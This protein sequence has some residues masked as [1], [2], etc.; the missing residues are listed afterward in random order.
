MNYVHVLNRCS[1]CCRFYGPTYRTHTQLVCLVGR[2]STRTCRTAPPNK[3]QNQASLYIVTPATTDST[4]ISFRVTCKHVKDHTCISALDR[5]AEF[6]VPVRSDLKS[7]T[8]DVMSPSPTARLG[9][10]NENALRSLWPAHM[11]QKGRGSSV[12]RSRSHR[13]KSWSTSKSVTNVHVSSRY[14]DHLYRH[15]L[16]SRPTS[17]ATSNHPEQA[18]ISDN[19]KVNASRQDKMTIN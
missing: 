2:A 18:R 16:S 6:H 7:K 4:I 17:T 1:L 3:N 10:A 12:G 9:S 8:T 15:H 19:G 13:V 11:S 5:P 14:S